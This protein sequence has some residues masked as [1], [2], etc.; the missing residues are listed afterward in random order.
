MG[1]FNYDYLGEESLE[2][3][4]LVLYF[5]GIVLWDMARVDLDKCVL[6]LI[7][8]DE[9]LTKKMVICTALADV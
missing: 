7:R 4:A 5:Y 9:S 3:S 2:T 1:V 6:K 8:T